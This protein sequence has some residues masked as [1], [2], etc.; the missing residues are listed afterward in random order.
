MVGGGRP[1]PDEAAAPVEV[2][3]TVLGRVYATPVRPTLLIPPT[4]RQSPRVTS[5]RHVDGVIIPPATAGRR[6]APRAVVRP[7][8][9][10]EARPRVADGLALEGR[11]ICVGITPL[12]GGVV[13]VTRRRLPAIPSAKEERP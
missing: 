8:P 11:P 6:V 5:G 13:V 7:A 1:P 2:G 3:V 9:V 10:G 12:A 4:L